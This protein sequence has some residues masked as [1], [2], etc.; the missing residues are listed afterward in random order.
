[1]RVKVFSFHRVSPEVDELWQPLHPD[2]FRAIIEYI[3]ENY[4]V[5][6][7]DTF[8]LSE[9]KEPADRPYAGITFDDGYKDILTYAYPVLE[10]YKLPFNIF[11]VTNCAETGIP[12]WTYVLDYMFVHSNILDNRVSAM[13]PDAFKKAKWANTTQR[14]EYAKELKPFLKECTNNYREKIVNSYIENFD[15][16]MLPKDILLTWSDI[17]GLHKKGVN[18]G[19]HSHTHPLLGKIEDESTIALE[20]KLS[21]DMLTD[22]LGH[23]PVSLS[24][25]VGSVDDRVKRIAREVGY[26]LGFAVNQVEYNSDE[27]DIFEIS[28]IELYDEGMF[29]TKLRAHGII[30]KMKHLF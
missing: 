8:M 12:P 26:K 23:E 24:Y 20:F 7:L 29:K 30:Q 27:E 3:V 10:E 28:R 22:R 6:N 15:D 5:V 17:Q 25:P 11:V 21:F 2:R 19:S 4:K 14:I 9:Y 16:V 13:L 18:I 1:M